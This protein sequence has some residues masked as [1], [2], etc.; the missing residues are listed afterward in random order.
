[1]ADPHVPPLDT[2]ELSPDETA[3]VEAALMTGDP[4][5]EDAA[6]LAGHRLYL[7]AVKQRLATLHM[8]RQD[9]KCCYCRKQ[10]GEHGVF[11][12]DREHILPKSKYGLLTY[13]PFNISVACKRCNM[14]VKGNKTDFVADPASIADAPTETDR[15]L[16][17]HPNFDRWD[18]H[19]EHYHF[20]MQNFTLV[21]YAVKPGSGKGAYTYEFFRLTELVVRSFDRAQ[22][23]AD[24]ITDLMAAFWKLK[25]DFEQ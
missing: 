4:W 24:M 20:Q 6:E 13:A 5:N 10:I 21:H 14:S 17:V 3:A 15:Y 9:N 11:L 23:G 8:Q 2:F 1:M 12:R 18:D 16:I 22:G 19:L 7:T 25:D